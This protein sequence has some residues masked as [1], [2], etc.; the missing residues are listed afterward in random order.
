[1]TQLKTCTNVDV[2]VN[3]DVSVN[4]NVDVNV[5]MYGCEWGCGCECEWGCGWGWGCECGCVIFSCG[6][7]VAPHAA[8]GDPDDH[9]AEGRKLS[10]TSYQY[11]YRLL[12]I[13]VISLPHRYY[14][15]I[16]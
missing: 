4:M 16:W 1:M 2:D 3:V 9:Q 10:R 15:D 7:H 11:L 6:D 13:D 5:L 8:R 14:I 12:D